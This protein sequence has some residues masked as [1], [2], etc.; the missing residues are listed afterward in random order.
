MG[1]RKRVYKPGCLQ[2][3]TCSGAFHLICSEPRPK[4]QCPTGYELANVWRRFRA[5][6]TKSWLL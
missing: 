3:R 5:A 6:T 2:L 4:G 1:T